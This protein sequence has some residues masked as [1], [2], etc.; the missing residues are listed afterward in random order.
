MSDAEYQRLLAQHERDME[1]LKGR[2]AIAMER[3]KRNFSD[4]L[5]ERQ[6]RK[7]QWQAEEEERMRLQEKLRASTASQRDEAHSSM[8]DE[9][10]LTPDDLEEFDME[11]NRTRTME[12]EE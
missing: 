4:K 7:A 10:I 3:Q 12:S 5:S 8:S 6:R 1:R 11:R 9:G 2:L